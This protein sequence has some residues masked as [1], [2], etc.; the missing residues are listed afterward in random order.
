[1]PPLALGFTSVS[2]PRGSGA[3]TSVWANLNL[4]KLRL[5]T[6]DR[7]DATGPGMSLGEPIAARPVARTPRSVHGWRLIIVGGWAVFILGFALGVPSED[8]ARHWWSDGAW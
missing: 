8:E 6:K 4:G 7:H 5:G 2:E 1:P 3:K